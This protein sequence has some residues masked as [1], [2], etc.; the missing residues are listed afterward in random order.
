MD[1]RIRIC[2]WM[3][4]G[5]AFGAILGGVFGGLTGTL[6]EQNRRAAG[7]GLAQRI[8][9][10]FERNAVRK[11]SP[12][13]RAI[14]IGATDGFLF[15]GVC[16]LTLGLILGWSDRGTG[17]IFPLLVG[18]LFLVAGAVCFG[19]LAYALSSNSEPHDDS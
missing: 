6:L 15:L 4:G 11:S 7:T 5:G 2:L 8:A 16:G 14:F 10:A 12:L 18:A 19:L 17:L 9:D 3:I 1:D 13:R